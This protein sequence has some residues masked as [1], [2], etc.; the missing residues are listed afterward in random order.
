[1]NNVTVQPL[2]DL[3]HRTYQASHYKLPNSNP[4]LVLLT[5]LHSEVCRFTRNVTEKLQFQTSLL[6]KIKQIFKFFI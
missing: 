2:A 1:M 6:I 5:V 4:V 3:L